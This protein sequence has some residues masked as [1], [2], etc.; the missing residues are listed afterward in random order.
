MKTSEKVLELLKKH[1]TT[2]ISGEEIAKKLQIS[3][4]SVWKAVNKL[5]NEGYSIKAQRKTGYQLLNFVESLNRDE[6]E[7]NLSEE[8]FG[9]CKTKIELFSEIDSTNTEAKKRLS[10]T[11]NSQLLKGTVLI[12]EKQTAGRG[13]LGRTFY[14][15]GHNGIYMSIIFKSEPEIIDTTVMT[16]AAAVAVC[17]VLETYNLAPKIKWVNDIFVNNKKI[18]GILTEG[19]INLETGVIDAIVLGIGLNVYSTESFSEELKEIAGVA[20]SQGC[21]VLPNRNELIARIINEVCAVFLHP[22]T[23]P[24]VMNE[25][26]DKSLVKDKIVTVLGA[27]KKYKARVIDI[28]PSAHLIVETHDGKKE[29][30]LSGEVSIKL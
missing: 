4:T 1:T 24:K 22:E 19:T 21:S 26:R 18:C 27:N 25:Y 14:S 9:F 2:S 15:P 3:R 28:T 30:L 8:A 7:K 11:M 29:E 5:I 23:I 13:R 10:G 6:I 12:A 20:F 16:A 17:R